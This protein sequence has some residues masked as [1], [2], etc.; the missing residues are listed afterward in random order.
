MGSDAAQPREWD[1]AFIGRMIRVEGY[2]W[3]ENTYTLEPPP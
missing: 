3:N 1:N 2:G